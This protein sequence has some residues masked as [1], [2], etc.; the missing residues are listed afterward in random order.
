MNVCINRF[1]WIRVRDYYS[2]SWD[3]ESFLWV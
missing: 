3:I 2:F 1:L